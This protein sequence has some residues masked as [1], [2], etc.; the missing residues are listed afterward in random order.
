[1]SIVAGV[2]PV[3]SS[4]VRSTGSASDGLGWLDSAWV[5][6]DPGAGWMSGANTKHRVC[7]PAG[8][9]V[10]LG[11][12]ATASRLRQNSGLV[13]VQSDLSVTVAVTH[14]L[15]TTSTSVEHELP[16]R[17]TDAHVQVFPLQALHTPRR[18]SAMD[19]QGR[20]G[21]VTILRSSER[22]TSPTFRRVYGYPQPLYV[23]DR[24]RRM[25]N[26]LRIERTVTLGSKKLFGKTA[27][28]TAVAAGYVRVNSSIA[29]LG[30]DVRFAFKFRFAGGALTTLGSLEAAAAAAVPHGL[31]GLNSS[32]FTGPGQDFRPRHDH[33]SGVAQRRTKLGDLHSLK[34]ATAILHVAMVFQPR[35]QLE[36]QTRRSSQVVNFE[37]R[38][39]LSVTTRVQAQGS[40]IKAAW[41]TTASLSVSGS[42]SF[43]VTVSGGTE[44]L[45]RRQADCGA[46]QVSLTL[47]PRRLQGSETP[48]TRV[49]SHKQ[50]LAQAEKAR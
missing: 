33:G 23:L 10:C 41:E 2:G 28:L 15:R 35:R 17:R 32:L 9:K 30:A 37:G 43:S 16:L 18:A 14:V 7:I 1:L 6:S 25:T 36:R 40:P 39:G 29:A 27:S 20:W 42:V 46:P 31:Q 5:G 21:E 38:A 13:W 47:R 19:S 8:R 34:A 49:V 12:D 48:Q 4:R 26:S 50:A 11:R 45:R 24:S 3:G 44:Q 22:A